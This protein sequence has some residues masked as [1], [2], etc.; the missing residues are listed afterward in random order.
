MA[1]RAVKRYK[2]MVIAN[3]KP[4]FTPILVR[5]KATVC[6]KGRMIAPWMDVS[7]MKLRSFLQLI[8]GPT[9]LSKN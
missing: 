9:P 1:E 5:E 7:G 4:F 3:K 2:M 6:I 8:R